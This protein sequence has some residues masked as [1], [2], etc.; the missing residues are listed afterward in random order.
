[1]DMSKL[2][3]DNLKFLALK[4][5]EFQQLLAGIAECF[6]VSLRNDFF[7]EF[8]LTSNEIDW[9]ILNEKSLTEH[10]SNPSERSTQFDIKKEEIYAV[11]AQLFWKKYAIFMGSIIGKIVFKSDKES[12]HLKNLFENL[13]LARFLIHHFRLNVAKTNSG[14]ETFAEKKR[15]FDVAVESNN[16][17]SFGLFRIKAAT[18]E[19]SEVEKFVGVEHEWAA[20]EHMQSRKA[21]GPWKKKTIE[22]LKKYINN[23]RK[24]WE[25]YP[26]TITV[27]DITFISN[28]PIDLKFHQQ[29]TVNASS[30]KWGGYNK[31]TWIIHAES[32][33]DLYLQQDRKKYYLPAS[34]PNQEINKLFFLG[35]VPS[36][37]DSSISF[38]HEA[39]YYKMWT[40]LE[41]KYNAVS[42]LLKNNSS[43]DVFMQAL[44]EFC[45]LYINVMPYRGGSAAI[46]EWMMRGL[47]KA[48][49]IELGAFDHQKLSWDFSAFVSLSAEEYGKQF[50]HFFTV[51]NNM[52]PDISSSTAAPATEHR[53][54]FFRKKSPLSKSIAMMSS[55]EIHGRY[56]K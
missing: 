52:R 6:N 51:F 32:S 28:K 26:H 4:N 35:N 16:S 22:R 23:Q 7:S 25:R 14:S 8:E 48:K 21:G 11:M 36:D 3:K 34:L 17:H 41:K 33:G 46:G 40:L 18:D 20:E 24:L 27:S 42:D 53:S 9:A 54:L 19:N 47:A 50:K 5:T 39:V 29:L 10:T 12:D 1:M 31:P 30:V 55:M 49:G 43:V 56:G 37:D 15:M 45:F 38:S 44:G 13:G 2:T